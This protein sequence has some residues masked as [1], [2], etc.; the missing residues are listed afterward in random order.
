MGKWMKKSKEREREREQE[1][2][3]GKKKQE[4]RAGAGARATEGGALGRF[5]PLVTLWVE[6]CCWT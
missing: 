2:E 4:A 6:R 5:V 1:Q 3:Q